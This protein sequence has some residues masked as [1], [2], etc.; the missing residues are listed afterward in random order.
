VTVRSHERD[1]CYLPSDQC[2][3]VA[4]LAPSRVTSNLD[5]LGLD[6]CGELGQIRRH[7]TL[8]EGRRDDDAVCAL[9]L[10]VSQPGEDE[11]LQSIQQS[12]DWR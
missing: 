7:G 10:G 2:H 9:A 11:G 1:W 12:L 4:L 6:F 3:S 5:A 8:G